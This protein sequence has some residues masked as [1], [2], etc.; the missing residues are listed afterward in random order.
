MDSLNSLDLL[1]L[2]WIWAMAIGGFFVD[3]FLGR[4]ILFA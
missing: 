4:R 2:D 1:A 3:F